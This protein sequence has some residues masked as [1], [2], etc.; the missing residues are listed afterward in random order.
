MIS[1]LKKAALSSLKDRWG[2]GVLS[3]FLYHV[4]SRVGIFI[5][6]FPLLLLG[7]LLSETMNSSYSITGDEKLNAVGA[8]SY[9]L[10]FVVLFI[11]LIAAQGIMNYGYCKVTLRL[12]KKESTTIGELF[13]GFRKSNVFRSIK[14]TIL[15][16]VYTLLWSVLLIVPGIIK[17]ISYSMAYYIL[18]DHPEYTAS[19]AIKKSQELMKGHKLDLFLLSLSFIGWFI[20]GI[21]IGFF[22]LGI[23]FLWIYPYY[24]TTVSH[25]YLNIVNRDTVIEGKTV[26]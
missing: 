18:I 14:V 4:I 13:E 2:L 11:C 10:V 22:T 25:F 15:M 3:S 7:I 24:I 16:T 20:L 23:P 19:E 6:G 9:L 8:F 17:F 5:V 26:I 12:A 21:I 1:D